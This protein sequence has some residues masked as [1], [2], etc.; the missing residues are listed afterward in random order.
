MRWLAYGWLAV[1]LVILG[2]SSVYKS[3]NERMYNP[4]LGINLVVIGERQIGILVLRPN[5]NIASYTLLPENLMI[6]D[7]NGSKYRIGSLWGLGALEHKAGEKVMVSLG[8]AMGLKISAFVKTGSDAM[9]DVNNLP[10]EI[11]I[12]KLNN[13]LNWWDKIDLNRDI[14]YWLQKGELV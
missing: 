5:E 4:R 12:W 3:L 13:N 10:E 8:R 14:R 1:A 2:L 11:A 9:L 7:E 6:K